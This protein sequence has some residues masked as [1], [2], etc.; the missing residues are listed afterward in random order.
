MKEGITARVGRIISGG[1]NQIID[2]VENAAP[3]AVLEQAIREVEG[4]MDEVRAELGRTVASKHLASRRL[5]EENERHEAL[6]GKIELALKEKRED[7]A[8]AAVAQQLDIEAQLPV[9]ESTIAE[10][11]A[12]EKELEGY[13][14]ALQAKRRQMKD[15]LRQFRKSREQA[16]SA[17]KA[18]SDGRGGVAG[19]K[20][21]VTVAHA[22]S[23]FDRV[24][25]KQTGLASLR[26]DLKT[27]S[28]LAELEDLS[29]KNR[30][31]ERLA[32]ARAQLEAK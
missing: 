3:E 9:L 24:I 1:F 15:E 4:A 21:E 10:C 26:S 16:A 27:T 29:R 12:R 7:L 19:G 5:M 17:A 28:Q 25:E 14:S 22:E 6:G 2:A 18:G 11:A 30:I 20:V 13:I 23:A 31:R 8:E 32:A